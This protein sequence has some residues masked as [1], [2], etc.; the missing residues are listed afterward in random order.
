MDKVLTHHN[1]GNT[2]SHW[3][4]S[5]AY[6]HKQIEAIADKD[7]TAGKTHVP[8]TSIPSPFAQMDLTLTAFKNAV[9][10][11]T[12]QKLRNVDFK[13]ISDCLDIGEI[14]FNLDKFKN[15][16][17]VIVWD[18]NIQLKALEQGGE[19]HHRLADA[20][21]LYLNQDKEHYNFG[22]LKQL[23]LLEYDHRIIGGTSSASLFFSSAND[24]SFVDITM[25]TGDK[26]LDKEYAHLY[27]R[28]IRYQEFWYSLKAAMGDSFIKK[29]PAIDTYLEINLGLLQSHNEVYHK[30]IKAITAET[31]QNEGTFANITI[32][33]NDNNKVYVFSDT[34]PMKKLKIDP[35]QLAETDFA[36]VAPKYKGLKKPLVLRVGHDGKDNRG[37]DLTYYENAYRNVNP[38]IPYYEAKG[39]DDR[40]LPGLTGVKYPFLVVSDFFEPYMIRLPYPVNM[41]QF[42]N[43]NL[44]TNRDNK[45]FVLPIKKLFFDFFSTEDLKNMLK[46]ESRAGGSVNVRL[47]IPIQ[48]G[49][50]VIFERLYSPTTDE[51]DV[52]P[53]DERKNEGTI[54]QH[55][56]GVTVYPFVKIN[57]PS[58][59][60]DYRV[61]LVDRDIYDHTKYHDYK[62]NFYK[63]EGNALISVKSDD[64]QI[65]YRTRKQDQDGRQTTAFFI[66]KDNFDY[67]QIKNDIAT[68]VVIPNFPSAEK[69]GNKQFT[70]AVDFGT[71][72]THIEY[73]DDVNKEPR[74]FDIT[75]ADLQIGTLHDRDFINRDASIN[76]TSATE[77]F[78]FPTEFFPEKISESGQY[79]FPQ[80][81]VLAQVEGLSE[82]DFDSTYTLADFN[83]PFIYEKQ[84]LLKGSQLYRNLKWSNS[85]AVEDKRR[86]NA[87]FEQLLVMMRAKVLRN[88]GNLS[89]TKLVAFYPSSM[90]GGRKQRFYRSWKELFKE[91]ISAD[92]VP[93]FVP[94][95]LA[96]YYHY[97]SG[98]AVQ[99][100]ASVRP[101]VTIDIGGGTTDVVIFK[102]ER[103]EKT[104]AEDEKVILQTSFRFAANAIF[105]DGFL[106][107]AYT[108][109]DHNGF[110]LRY[111][112]KIKKLISE[113]RTLYD[114][115][116]VYQEIVD[117]NTRSEDIITFF[118]SLQNNKEFT[119]KSKATF[120]K[121]LE[122]DDE[123]RFIFVIF[124]MAIIYHVA[125]L[126]Y[127]KGL[128]M[129]AYVAFSGNGSRV[130]DILAPD[131]KTLQ[132]FAGVIIRKVYSN[133]RQAAKIETPQYEKTELTVAR[134][135]NRPKEATCKGGLKLT[136]E[137]ENKLKDH[138]NSPTILLGIGKNTKNIPTLSSEGGFFSYRQLISQ[139]QEI[140]DL[141]EKEVL[142][143]I[144]FIFD[145]NK[146]YNFSKK[147]LVEGNLNEYK[148]LLLAH[149][150]EDLAR[151]LDIKMTEINNGDAESLDAP[152]EETLFFYPLIPALN[153]LALTI[154]QKNS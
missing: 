137:E 131:N 65:R 62:L 20:L 54:M 5:S 87:F 63:N 26:M 77:I 49:Q 41:Q 136:P 145:I 101:A 50:K 97:K 72:N 133:E 83:I 134:D 51:F 89:R 124:Y 17:R 55:E 29:F 86:V 95:S 18:R 70:F 129:P 74:P 115:E 102:K 153:R 7:P 96:P 34:Y 53:P 154:H 90:D 60:P 48:K 118:F 64:N 12:L 44:Q 10:D 78:Q 111:K 76:G 79:R 40:H 35:N 110:V 80:R 100:N 149:I 84:V 68:G 1:T 130:L 108:G 125:K 39:L 43:G 126:M 151:G 37:Q 81:T 30:R 103:D 47:E 52:R 138:E 112:E 31:Y 144:N 106:N 142:D 27:Q 8:P 73:I 143:F 114:L 147:L 128:Q 25:S 75:E 59:T 3:F 104:G 122:D 123:M 82:H 19:P 42:F 11:R 121:M 22:D 16:T 85:K 21:N 15:K 69:E 141:V 94:E 132:D 9:K 4:N 146:E 116:K 98:G 45:G 57:T 152:I 32:D 67:I 127:E 71:T 38:N 23:F 56:I 61:L 14:F 93:L 135:L 36:I 148:T 6:G 2:G 120:T 107:T 140:S 117:T 92:N 66:V 139:K 58:V 113:G 109:K 46:L 91:Y 24:T 33:Q 88:G 13:L 28:D 150:D 119:T 105:G 99:V